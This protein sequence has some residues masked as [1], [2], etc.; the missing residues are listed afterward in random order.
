MG[1]LIG[2][3]VRING[4][5]LRLELDGVFGNMSASTNQLDPQGLDETVKSDVS[6][7][8]T[9]RTGLEHQ[10]GPTT[11]FANGGL[12]IARISNSVT[13]IDF[14]PDRFPQ[15]DPDDSF[16][17]NSIHIGWVIGAGAEMPLS[18]NNKAR[19]LRDDEGWILR[20]E[21][22][23]IDL[24]ENTYEVNHSGGNS[25]GPGGPRRPC[26]YRIENKVGLVRLAIIKRFSL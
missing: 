19:F 21:G 23:Y 17:D 13:D 8:L 2:K 3:K 5:P 1:V 6:W 4:M 18:K 15:E 16:S 14:G 7:I 20:L 9:A 25:C 12:A 24:G 10:L 11:L 26:L 22:S